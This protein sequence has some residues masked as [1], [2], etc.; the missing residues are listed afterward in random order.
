MPPHLATSLHASRRLT[1]RCAAFLLSLMASLSAAQAAS[2]GLVTLLEGEAVLLR[3]NAKFA[4][5]EGLSLSRDDIIDMGAKGRF[6]LVEFKD[7]SSLAIGPA[8][9]VQIAPHLAADRGKIDARIYLL[10]G[11]VKVSA[12]KAGSWALNASAFDLSGLSQDAVVFAQG[13]SGQVFA[14]AGGVNV[15]PVLPNGAASTKLSSGEFLN[16]S[17]AAKP[18]LTQRPPAGFLQSIPRAFQDKLP[19][20]AA[21]FQ[22]KETTAKRLGE[23]SYADAQA[24]LNAEPALRKA[25]L[26]RWKPLAHQAEFRKGLVAEIKLHPEWE[27]ILF[28][29][30]AATGP[31]ASPSTAGAAK[32]WV[33]EK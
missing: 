4:L 31:Q 29:P 24:W 16:L 23:L 3:D 20:R 18:E 17:G 8:T 32:N 12:A 1:A 26:V 28:P 5:S 22:G 25:N 2:L 19:S 21:L 30:Q 10:Q 6:M 7:G 11:W 27:Q 13:S 15:K 14:E 9:S 33:S